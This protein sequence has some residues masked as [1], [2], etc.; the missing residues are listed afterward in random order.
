[1]LQKNIVSMVVG[2]MKKFINDPNA[3]QNQLM[4]NNSHNNNNIIS[5]KWNR[6][7]IK[8]YHNR[9]QKEIE[10]PHFLTTW[11]LLRWK[12]LT[13]N[14]K[15]KEENICNTWKQ[16]GTHKIKYG[17]DIG[18]KN[19]NG[20]CRRWCFVEQDRTLLQRRLKFIGAKLYSWYN[21]CFLIV[22]EW[23]YQLR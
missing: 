9:N 4:R 6:S 19:K 17:I 12:H 20:V 21:V 11:K 10:D 18:K 7:K 2:L 1:M 23:M 13:K 14:M 3:K 22:S 8:E 15:K 5:H 16:K